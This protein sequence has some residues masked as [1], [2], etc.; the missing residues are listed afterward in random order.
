MLNHFAARVVDQLVPVG[1][2]HAAGLFRL[3]LRR[4]LVGSDQWDLATSGIAAGIP[5]LV[6][7]G[8][9]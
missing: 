4:T 5:A 3:H 7:I 9:P 1:D 8:E 2:F 6:D